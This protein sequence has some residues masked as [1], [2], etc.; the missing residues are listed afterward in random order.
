MELLVHL[1]MEL[2]QNKTKQAHRYKG[3]IGGGPRWGM[4]VGEMD[5][6]VKE[7]KLSAIK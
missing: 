6:G 2:K 5:E 3:Q 1:Y 7:Y 4:R